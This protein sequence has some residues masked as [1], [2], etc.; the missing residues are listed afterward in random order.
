MEAMK[1]RSLID[2]TSVVVGEGRMSMPRGLKPWEVRLSI[3]A[4]PRWP[5]EPVTRTSYDEDILKWRLHESCLL[6]AL[7]ISKHTPLGHNQS[8]RMVL[9]MSG[10]LLI[11][12]NVCYSSLGIVDLSWLPQ[13]FWYKHDPLQNYSHFIIKCW[14]CVM[15]PQWG[16]GEAQKSKS[17]PW[18]TSHVKN[19]PWCLTN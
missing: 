11:S 19:L 17:L 1:S 3:R 15:N 9:L 13:K 14:F 10:E 6:W 16:P 18:R 2:P 8:I 7:S 5:A 12:K 4:V